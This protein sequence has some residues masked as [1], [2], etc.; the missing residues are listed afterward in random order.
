MKWNSAKRHHSPEVR[1]CEGANY[2]EVQYKT[3]ITLSLWRIRMSSC[4][5]SGKR[6]NVLWSLKR[7]KWSIGTE[8]WVWGAMR[9]WGAKRGRAKRAARA[10]SRSQY[11]L[12]IIK[13]TLGTPG[14][15]LVLEATTTKDWLTPE[16]T[17]HRTPSSPFPD[18]N[19]RET[20]FHETISPSA[21][22][23]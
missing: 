23:S 5:N 14:K 15:Q 17:R 18:S 4:I 11:L 22:G 19:S 20:R 21:Q 7:V 6:P 3:V 10:A 12:Q 1:R 9:R 16:L 2:K 13:R 8:E